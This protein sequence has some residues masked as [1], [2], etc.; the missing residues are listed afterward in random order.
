MLRLRKYGRWYFLGA[1]ALAAFFIWQAVFWV[2]A[3]RG[4]VMLH[5][6]DVGQGDAMLIE[7]PNGNQVL[8]D[9]GPDSSVLAR[10]G[11]VLPFWDRSLELVILTH[12]HADHLGGL[13]EVLRRYDVGM[14]LES[15]VNHSIPEY[16]AWRGLLR[17]QGIPVVTARAGERLRISDSAVLDILTP[18]RNFAGQSPRDVHD[19]MVV[20]KLVHGRTTFLLMGDA[21]RPLERELIAAGA[22]LDV[23]VLKAGHHGSK[24]STAEEF[25]RATTPAVAVISVGRRNRYGHPAQEVLDRLAPFG[26]AVLRTDQDGDITLTSD[27][28]TFR[29]AGD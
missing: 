14:V 7:A 27:G 19:A 3:R 28:R 4:R 2:E 8:I 12:P 21:E 29:Y 24:T 1:L 17:D 13:I 6:F 25:L 5:F 11:D 10:L 15:G 20:A 23:D 26:I 16:A 22:D 18:L 9:G